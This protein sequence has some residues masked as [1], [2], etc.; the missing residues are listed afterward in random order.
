MDI[1]IL[2][3]K[4]WRNIFIN[5]LIFK[6]IKFFKI[7]KKIKFDRIE[8]IKDF[9]KREYISSIVYEGT[10][11]LISGK[12]FP[13]GVYS[14]RISYDKYCCKK[15]IESQ[16]SF[17]LKEFIFPKYNNRI[18]R[19]LLFPSSVETVVN[20]TFIK[21]DRNDKN[22]QDTHPPKLKH[23]IPYNIKSLS[24]FRC[25][26]HKLSKWLSIPNSLTSLDLGPYWFNR[27]KILKPN[28]L[29]NQLTHL[30]MSIV[31]PIFIIKK[32]CLPNKLESLNLSV[33]S[34]YLSPENIYTLENEII[35]ESNSLPQSLKKLEINYAIPIFV[36]SIDSFENITCLLL[37][38]YQEGYRTL[39]KYMFPPH[40][41]TL[42]LRVTKTSI[43]P[44]TLPNSIT[45]L[46]LH[47]YSW[48]SY[49]CFD[50]EHSNF[51]PTSLKK[52]Q[53]NSKIK[54]KVYINLPNTIE[55]LKFG[56]F[57]N[58][59]I[60][61]Q[62]VSIPKSVLKLTFNCNKD[63]ESA[64]IP[65]SIKYLKFGR[66]V[67]NNQFQTITIPETTETLVIKSNQPFYKDFIPPYLK[68]LK[69]I[70]DFDKP[71]LFPLPITLEKLFIGNSFNQSL[72][73][74]LLPQSIIF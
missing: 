20:A 12:D 53:L 74:T 38:Y 1:E 13:R 5:R 22:L 15:S 71:I 6:H 11:E 47:D 34:K 39:T 35:F 60:T 24:I 2:F 73:E 46:K 48:E 7:Y 66:N 69:L 9:P 25:P 56:I 29:P 40:L 10:K 37:N 30:S 26:N 64:V 33:S 65:N 58:Q 41:N 68:I 45:S 42:S 72:N 50:L 16:L 23:I 57:Y 4:V 3:F 54:G 28:D 52:L 17:G 67:L 63:I 59:S 70:G 19:L 21:F 49:N 51:F 27:N 8:D 18:T 61:F 31:T 55:N 62:S 44:N 43:T 14:I 36:K 32:D